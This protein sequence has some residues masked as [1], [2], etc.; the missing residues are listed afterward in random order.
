MSALILK[1]PWA[2]LVVNGEKT[3][4]I[5]T[6]P[7]NKIGKEIYIAKAGTKTLIGKV[8]ITDCRRLTPEEFQNLSPQHLALHY[9][10]PP[11]KKIY[12]WFL[13]NAHPFP[14]PIPYKHPQGAQIW[15]KIP[16]Q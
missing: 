15:V 8:T 14:C 3:I 4:E 2:T 1:E 11:N 6:M 7:T 9:S 12:G 16:N 13:K 10:F 5:R